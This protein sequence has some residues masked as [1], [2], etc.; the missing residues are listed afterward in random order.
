MCRLTKNVSNRSKQTRDEM[1]AELVHAD[2]SKIIIPTV[3]REDYLNGLRRL[4]RKSDPSVIIKAISRVRQ[5]S[6]NII[7]DDFEET[8]RYLYCSLLKLIYRQ[9]LDLISIFLNY[10]FLIHR[11]N[12]QIGAFEF[13]RTFYDA[14]YLSLERS[15]GR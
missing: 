5:F 15:F 14:I 6:A 10:P 2:Q 7:G 3:F 13:S 8:C 4:T 12:N 9:N 11:D 1:N